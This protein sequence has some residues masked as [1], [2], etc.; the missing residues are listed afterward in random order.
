MTCAYERFNAR[1]LGM[2]AAGQSGVRGEHAVP[3]DA[4]GDGKF[5]HGTEDRGFEIE[6]GE[7]EAGGEAIGGIERE[8]GIGGDYQP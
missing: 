2:A 8:V 6:G 5:L 3:I 1:A 4:A 7:P